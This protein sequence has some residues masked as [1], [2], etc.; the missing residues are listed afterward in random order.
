MQ[1]SKRLVTWIVIMVFSGIAFSGIAM[2]Q[3]EGQKDLSSYMCKDVMRSSGNERDLFIG[4][5]HAFILGKK[6]TPK[7]DEMKLA[8]ATDKFIDHCLDNPNDKALEV[9]EKLTK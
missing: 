2:G 8:E 6:G 4:F 5:I 7:F 9:M 3:E 1:V